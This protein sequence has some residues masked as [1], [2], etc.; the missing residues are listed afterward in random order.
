MPTD[1]HMPKC[2]VE[3]CIKVLLLQV[4][5]KGGDNEI[6]MI[7]E[8]RYKYGTVMS[9]IAICMVFLKIILHEVYGASESYIA[10]GVAECNITFRITIHLMQYSF[11]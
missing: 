8:I 9:A 2:I 10:G 5:F 3:F 11:S 7:C 6:W 1:V 4:S